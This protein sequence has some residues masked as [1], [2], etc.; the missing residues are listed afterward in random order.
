[1]K[2]VDAEYSMFESKL[3]DPAHQRACYILLA[4]GAVVLAFG[5]YLGFVRH[6]N[7]AVVFV[8]LGITTAVFGTVLF[9]LL[10]PHAFAFLSPAASV[11]QPKAEP[12]PQPQ[13]EA[14]NEPQF[15][16]KDAPV[17]EL[18]DVPSPSSSDVPPP[19]SKAGPRLEDGVEPP[20]QVKVQIGRGT[21][22]EPQDEASSDVVAPLDMTLGDILLAALR[23]D[24][25]G[26]GRIF[27]RAIVQA[28]VPIAAVKAAEPKTE[29]QPESPDPV[30]MS[31]ARRGPNDSG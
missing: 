5:L 18:K 22:S 24:P 12:Q 13:P 10:K 6:A 26:A 4:V 25:Q 17:P 11:P 9:V 31:P 21:K 2:I 28:D 16:A 1:V 20:A 14:N 27:A 7:S 19:D 3:F 30:D 15:E 8:S 29:L 23:K